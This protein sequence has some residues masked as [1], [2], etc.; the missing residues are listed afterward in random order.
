[1]VVGD[2]QLDTLEATGKQ[3]LQEAPPVGL[4]F[5]GR[6]IAAQSPVSTPTAINTAQ[7]RRWSE[8]TF[9]RK[10]SVKSRANEFGSLA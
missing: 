3:V 9:G 7:S 6:D 5:R 4:G 8:T 2:D 10:T 1:M